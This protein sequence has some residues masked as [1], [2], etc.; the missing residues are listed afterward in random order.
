M[1]DTIKFIDE[2]YSKNNFELSVDYAQK[3]RAVAYIETDHCSGSGFMFTSNG[4]CFTCAHVIKN[5]SK[6]YVRLRVDGV[7]VKIYSAKVLFQNDSLD[8]AILQLENCDSNAFFV[9]ETDFSSIKSGDDIA[10]F[11]FPFGKDLNNDIR[12][13]EPTLTKGYVAS[14][15]KI[16]EQTCYYLD[17][18]SAPGN[19]GGPIFSKNQKVFGY[20]CGSY[21]TDR[22]N[23]VYM[24]TLE[25]FWIMLKDCRRA[26]KKYPKLTVEVAKEFEVLL[27]GKLMPREEDIIKMLLGITVDEPMSPLEIS[28]I[29]D[30][31]VNR[32]YQI[33]AKFLRMLRHQRK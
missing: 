29:Y 27:T 33:E 5:S 32:I 19:S 18:R 21:G 2:Q 14:K 10:V 11:G 12:T 8:Y 26:N 17:V 20:L 6:I 9:L 23:L 15:N 3:E 31:C 13:L 28:K 30:V 4:L 25:S 16:N 24:R 22:S 1:T 7:T